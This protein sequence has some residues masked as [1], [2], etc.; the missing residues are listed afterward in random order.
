MERRA[1]PGHLVDLLPLAK[2]ISQLLDDE[3]DASWQISKQSGAGAPRMVVV[4]TAQAAVLQ[5]YSA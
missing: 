2:I 4:L 3:D 5:F 1:V